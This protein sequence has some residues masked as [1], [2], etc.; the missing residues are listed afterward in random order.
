MA[1][2]VRVEEARPP[3]KRRHRAR[4]YDRPRFLWVVTGLVV[5]YLFAPIVVVLL[6]SFNDRKSL[7]SFGGF[8]LR[9]YRDFMTNDGIR[10]SL[11]F[12]LEIAVTVMVVAAVLGTLMALGLK[13]A[14]SR[15]GSLAETLLLLTLVAPELATAVAVMLLFSQ[16]KVPLSGLT[17]VLGHVTFSIVFVALI[18]RSRLAG[19]GPEIEEAALDLGCTPL[20]AVWLVTVPLLWPAIMAGSLLAFVIS[21]DNFVTSYFLT[22]I[23]TPPL[24]VTIYS[25]IRFG[26]S[27]T[28]NAVGA[29]MMALTVLVGLVAVVI[30]VW[31]TRRLRRA[32]PGGAPAR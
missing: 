21:F 28:I 29:F 15:F 1:T 30:Y 16:L 19:I 8:S 31:G 14:R 25:M 26:I 18:V 20:K 4:G 23:G 3:A 27:P 5:A 2:A 12:S 32:T 22:G 10:A 13:Y 7:A 11:L 17:V 24:P 9:W 6:F